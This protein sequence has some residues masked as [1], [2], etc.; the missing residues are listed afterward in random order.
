MLLHDFEPPLFPDIGALAHTA[1]A[2]FGIG[3]LNLRLL[4]VFLIYHI[5][6]KM[7]VVRYLHFVKIDFYFE[8][9]IWW[10]RFCPVKV[11]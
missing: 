9:V 5:P 2:P 10:C 3:L 8:W 1:V 6:E 4:L 7:M 11:L